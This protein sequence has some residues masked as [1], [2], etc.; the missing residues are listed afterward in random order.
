MAHPTPEGLHAPFSPQMTAPSSPQLV[1]QQM[2]PSQ[3]PL[4]HCGPALQVAPLLSS[5]PQIPPVQV[6]PATQSPLPV[7]DVLQLVPPH[8]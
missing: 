5:D 8:L 3:L 2:F 7:Q 4:E 6:C 1:E